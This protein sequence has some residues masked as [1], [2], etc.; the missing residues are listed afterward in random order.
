MTYQADPTNPSLPADSAGSGYA[1]LE[2][3]SIKQLLQ[4]YKGE[5]EDADSILTAA[6]ESEETARAAADTTL[7]ENITAEATARADADTALQNEIDAE[8]IARANG[9]NALQAAINDLL[10]N[11][12]YHVGSYIH[13]DDNTF[14]P[15]VALSFGVWE[16]LPAGH[17]LYSRDPLEGNQFSVSGSE[18]GSF[19][20]IL[21]IDEIPSHNHTLTDPG[22]EHSYTWNEPPS[23][24]DAGGGS[25]GSE[26]PLIQKSGIT[27]NVQTGISIAPV[28]GGQAFSLVSK[29][30][31]TNIWKRTS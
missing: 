25:T 23:R 17:T 29:G 12:I 18:V 26:W 15:N 9:D 6:I 24:E 20:K 19:T 4:T 28:G 7:Q 13:T 3:R 30:N 8:E 31:V 27:G 10:E 1:A 2:L 5:W 16:R 22:H 14:D 21:S 11:T